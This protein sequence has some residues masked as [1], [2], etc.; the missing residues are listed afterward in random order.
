[1]ARVADAVVVG[2]TLV[3]RVGELAGTPER[4]VPEVTAILAQ[5]RQ[6]IDA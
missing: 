1:V 2:S 5:M 6:A 3:R 4:I